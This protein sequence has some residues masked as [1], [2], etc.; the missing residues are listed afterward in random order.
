MI[1]T[2]TPFLIL[3]TGSTAPE[4]I[5]R[6]GDYDRWFARAMQGDAGENSCLGFTV[7]DVTKEPIPDPAAFAGVVVTGSTRSAYER[8]PWMEPL[9]SYLAEVERHMVPV[10][11]VCF[12]MQILAQARGGQVILNPNGWEIGG[13]DVTFTEA[14]TED[15]LFAGLPPLIKV[16][17]THEDRVEA[18]PPGAVLL[19]TNRSSPVQ[20]FCASDRVWGVQFHPEATI[21][22]I[23]MLIRLRADQLL[24]DAETRGHESAGHVQRLLDTLADPQVGQGRHV[25]DRFVRMCAETDRARRPTSRG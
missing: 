13:T 6:H 8:E 25:L 15:P 3:R 11:C 1:P 10:L 19:A 16:L 17:A 21:P 24:R 20:A 2:S 12:G 18:L 5:H 4:V 9:C 23:E 22:I 14:A 7:C